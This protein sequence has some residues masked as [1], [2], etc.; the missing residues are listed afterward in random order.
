MGWRGRVL[1][2]RLRDQS[3]VVATVLLVTLVATTLLGTFALLLLGS[4][5]DALEEALSRADRD[6]V[7]VEAALRV[8]KKDAAPVVDAAREAL[9]AVT[10]ALE[11]HDETWLGGSLWRLP[12]ASA[13]GSPPLAYPAA[14]PRQHDSARLVEGSWPDRARDDAGRLLVAVPSVAARAYGWTVGTVV[15]V[16]A[17]TGATA[18]EWLVTGMHELT[19]RPGTWSRDRLLGGSHDPL[20]PVP[21]SGGRLVTDAWG[22]MLVDP[23]ALAG[24][25]RVETANVVVEPVLAGA[26][27]GAVADMRAAVDDAQV[28]LSGSL[29]GT[30]AYGS[31]RTTVDR[32]V[33]GAW[34][35]LTV[36]RVGVVVVGLLL[37]VL[38]TTVMLLAARLLGERR[39]AEGELLASRGSAPHQLRS[40]AVLE[41]L[42]LAVVCAAAA[43]WLA[44][45][46]WSW[47]VASG[48]LAPAGFTVPVG[49]PPAVVLT[50]AVV[51]GTLAVALVVPQWHVAGSSAPSAH[52]GMVRTGADLALVAL[53]GVTLW[54]LL[55]YG[56][57]MTAGPAGPRLDPLLATGPALVALAA[58]VLALRLV[59]PVAAGADALARRSRSL[60]APL[61]AWQ[62]ARRPA[63]ASGTTLVLVLA[64][65][66]AVFAQ[67]FLQTWR[68]SQLEQVDLATGT[69]V[70][71]DE[72]GGNRAD[73]SRTVQQ[74]LAAHPG[75]SAQPVVDRSAS[76]GKVAGADA[77]ATTRGVHL[78]A[79]DTTR[80]QALRGRTDTSWR[81]ATSALAPDDRTAHVALPGDPQWLVLDVA[82]TLTPHVPSRGS[83]SVVVADVHGVRTWLDAQ[84]PYIDPGT[85][86]P[87]AIEIPPS[88]GPLVVD[89]V[90]G[91]FALLEPPPD[92]TGAGPPT[93]QVVLDLTRVRVVDRSVGAGAAA[94]LDAPATAVPLADAAWD[95]HALSGGLERQVTGE[96]AGD[97]LRLVGEFDFETM[98]NASAHLVATTWRV[99]G[100]APATI[101]AAL[102]EA[103]D[104]RPRDRLALTVGNVSVSL[105]V[106]TIVPYLPG[107]PRGPSV[108]VDREALTRLLLATGSDQDLVDGWWLAAAPGDDGVALGAALHET[109][110]GEVTVRT[111]EQ[112]VAT[113]GPLRVGVPVALRL[114]GLA[115]AALLVVGLGTSATV[116]VRSRRL[117]LA[118]LQALGAPRGALVG[119]L[120]AEHALLVA[121][122][123]AAG[124]VIGY[125]LAAVIA[126][127]LTVSA[128]GRS[129]V[130]APALVWSWLGQ[131]GA[132]GALAAAA[133]LTVAVV[134][135]LLVRRASG[136][137]LR[138]G[139]D[140]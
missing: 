18:D 92:D 136:A 34:R 57:P 113:G 139:D 30:G 123:T 29:R 2:R 86:Q 4:A 74:V 22:P 58:S 80:P 59:Q 26:P 42:A 140:R 83:L 98:V 44:R 69:D 27:D 35:E 3:A 108:L 32:T 10:G 137:L 87:F 132:A 95:G 37:T 101:S 64:V 62:V 112:D 71:V 73:G 110:L 66:C 109:G 53:G 40:L 72:L 127:L 138:L 11:T 50:C 16:R 118:R 33:D 52:A 12:G 23:A 31:V 125:G 41:A 36:T 81:A 61:A 130:P 7:T 24:A 133:C 14:S 46:V 116:A 15:P 103:N 20:F 85:T 122:G 19:G 126:P 102:A 25:D 99:Q 96:G 128:D 131:L 5:E 134:A 39:S 94:A 111:A 55:D 106:D 115:A 54:Q 97:A 105:W 100:S 82:V 79:V 76:A 135:V 6:D 114:V 89:D 51:A 65:A 17:T 77:S 78:L 104:L 124:L 129:P 91:R 45:G 67:S 49:V 60:V 8:N 9:H 1:T 47:L 121:L 75:A 43:P 84:L 90:V 117:E 38:A 21:G 119:G 107:A 56:T 28:A 63:A 48:P 13:S 68:L 88:A 93:D 120:V 70:R